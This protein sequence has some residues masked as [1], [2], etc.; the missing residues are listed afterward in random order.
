MLALVVDDS[1][2]TRMIL[3]SVLRQL[4]FDVA[5]AVNGKEAIESLRAQTQPPDVVLL[6]WNMPVMDGYQLLRILRADPNYADVP[7]MMVSSENKAELIQRALTAGASEYVMKPFTRDV[8]REKLEILGLKIVAGTS[9]LPPYSS[10]ARLQNHEIR[11]L[12]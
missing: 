11:T 7:I 2:T 5:E 10:Q 12:E 1:R 4:G 3:G 9:P 6:D 8:I